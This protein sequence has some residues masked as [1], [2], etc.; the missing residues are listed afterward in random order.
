MDYTIYSIEDRSWE[1]DDPVR[2]PGPYIVIYRESHLDD[3]LRVYA[4]FSKLSEIEERFGDISHIE[5]K[6]NPPM[7]D[8][9]KLLQLYKI[10]GEEPPLWAIDNINQTV[11]N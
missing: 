3:N 6:V 7:L 9:N 1:H 10:I 4:Q 11:D 2:R 5:I 8:R